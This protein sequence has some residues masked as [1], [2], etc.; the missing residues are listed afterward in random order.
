MDSTWPPNNRGSF[1]VNRDSPSV[2]TPDSVRSFGWLLVLPYAFARTFLSSAVGLPPF[3]AT[4]I[5]A[6]TLKFPFPRFLVAGF[7]GRLLRF[8]LIVAVPA[9]GR[10]VVGA[11]S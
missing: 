2:A 5:L 6:G 8:G 11:S 4:A 7:L 3:F 10:W 1:V 9:L